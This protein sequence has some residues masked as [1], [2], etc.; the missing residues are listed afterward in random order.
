MGAI[1]S[2]IHGCRSWAWSPALVSLDHE[3]NTR[4]SDNVQNEAPKSYSWDKKKPDVSQFIIEN[5]EGEEAGRGIGTI[6]G[7]QFMIR[8][9]QGA[10]IYLFD[11][12]NTVTID[13]CKNCKIF[14]GPTKVRIKLIK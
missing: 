9:C 1:H 11:H 10:N 2:C 5:L 13:D 7:Q 3:N 6:N 12:T 8:N 4:P 14:V